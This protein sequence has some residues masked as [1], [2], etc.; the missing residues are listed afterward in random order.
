MRPPRSQARKLRYSNPGYFDLFLAQATPPPGFALKA[1]ALP[2]CLA[3][4]RPKLLDSTS[5]QPDG[6]QGPLRAL[7]CMAILTM[8]FLRRRG[9]LASESDTRQ[10]DISSRSSKDAEKPTAAVRS[11]G[12]AT[13]RND[14]SATTTPRDSTTSRP[15]TSHNH[16]DLSRQK[17]FSVLRF[18]NASDSQLS[19][20]AKQ[21]AEQLP[22][23]PSSTLHSPCHFVTCFLG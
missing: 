14:Q 20:K 16:D 1:L 23:L 10:Q 22:P 19:L 3:C 12:Q 6:H 2:S 5:P 13:A 4:L 17:R 15:D 9:N 11:D 8:P 21:Q 18:R 7:P